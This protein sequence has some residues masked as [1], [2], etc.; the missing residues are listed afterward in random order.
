MKKEWNSTRPTA[1]EEEIN[2]LKEIMAMQKQRSAELKKQREEETAGLKKIME[3]QKAR[4]KA[5]LGK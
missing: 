2:G 4:R 5:I 3:Q 1:T